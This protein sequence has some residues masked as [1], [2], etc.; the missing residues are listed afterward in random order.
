[1]AD[2]QL[3]FGGAVVTVDSSHRVLDPG[4]VVV[5]NGVITQLGEGEPPA[6]VVSSVDD[7]VS[8]VGC[9]V[10]PGMTNAHT[11][12]FQSFFRGLADD[13]PLLD[14]LRECIW[15]AAEHITPEIAY[16]AAQIGL[17]ENLLT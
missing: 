11:H 10:M 4:W 8:A 16:H 6:D 14:W 17:L 13:R 9:A 3:I 1:M 7:H 5:S 2:S 12:L 15:P